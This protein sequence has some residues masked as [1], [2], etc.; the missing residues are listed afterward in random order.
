M[1]EE[2]L[3]Y[4]KEQKKAPTKTQSLI[5]EI[6]KQLLEDQKVL[7]TEIFKQIL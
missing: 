5:I 2:V 7:T 4:I 3:D 1:Y 6:L